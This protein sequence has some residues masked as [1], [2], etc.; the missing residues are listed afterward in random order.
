M[1]LVQGKP[2]AVLY[3]QS[4]PGTP[5]EQRVPFASPTRTIY[6][7]RVDNVSAQLEFARAGGN[8]EFSIP[9]K[10]L[11]LEPRAEQTIRADVGV[12]HGRG[13]QT[14]QRIYWHNKATAITT[15]VPSEAALTPQL[16]GQWQ[17]KASSP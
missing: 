1:T 11:G 9:L 17:F 12:L 5:V 6:F 16:W 4:V 14:T 7:D 3:R 8:Y 10:T 13:G 2:T 15:D